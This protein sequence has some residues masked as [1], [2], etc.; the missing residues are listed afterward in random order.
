MKLF[1]GRNTA[2]EVLDDWGFDGPVL[3]PLESVQLTFGSI[4]LY[5]EDRVELARVDDLI[6]YDGKFYGDAQVCL[7]SEHPPTEQVDAQKTECDA[8]LRSP[9]PI[10][11][12][13]DKLVVFL[14]CVGV[15]IDS[16]TERVGQRA[17]HACQLALGRFGRLPS[18]QSE[19]ESRLINAG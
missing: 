16:V 6:F 4:A 15:F 1:H 7:A 18:P 11:L 2:T 9:E 17:A 19:R 3:G 10:V 12:E 5:A 14:A 13:H 8:Q